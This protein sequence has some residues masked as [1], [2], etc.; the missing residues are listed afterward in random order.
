M[1]KTRVR[2]AGL[3][4]LLLTLSFLFSGCAT[5]KPLFKYALCDYDHSYFAH[6]NCN[7]ITSDT[8]LFDP[9]NVTLTFHYGRLNGTNVKP[10]DVVYMDIYVRASKYSH[11]NPDGSSF[12]MGE[13]ESYL[14]KRVEDDWR[15]EKYLCRCSYAEDPTAYGVWESITVPKEIFVHEEGYFTVHVQ[16]PATEKRGEH[17]PFNMIIMRYQKLRSG[18]IRISIAEND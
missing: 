6:G 14:I 15:S 11:F 13:G 1:K 5:E 7:A 16:F 18:K 12:I 9:D 10:E 4:A 2:F 17:I 8:D 3:F